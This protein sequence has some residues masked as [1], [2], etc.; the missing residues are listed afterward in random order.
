MISTTILFTSVDSPWTK[1]R[2]AVSP[3]LSFKSRASAFLLRVS[4]FSWESWLITSLS[5]FSVVKAREKLFFRNSTVSV[6]FG[7]LP[8]T[9]ISTQFSTLTLKRPS[10]AMHWVTTFFE[11]CWNCWNACIIWTWKIIILTVWTELKLP[12]KL[13]RARYITLAD[14]VVDIWNPPVP[15]AGM[16]TEPR[17]CVSASRKQLSRHC[18]RWL[19]FAESDIRCI[20]WRDGSFPLAVITADPHG[21]CRNLF[22]SSCIRWPPNISIVLLTIPLSISKSLLTIFTMASVFS[23]KRSPWA[24]SISTGVFFNFLCTF[25]STLNLSISCLKA[26]VNARSCW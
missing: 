6:T 22:N 25:C 26:A 24:T 15:T 1:I 5:T 10:N 4:I 8:A 20:M 7:S 23:W 9:Q 13:L 16:E 17:P 21:C 14:S 2:V 19:S 11:L 12:Q 18:W 3:T